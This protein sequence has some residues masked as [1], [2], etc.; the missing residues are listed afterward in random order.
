MPTPHQLGL[1]EHFEQF[2]PNQLE[3][4]AKI[5]NDS[6]FAFLLEAPTGIGKTVIS[7]TAQAL[8]GKQAIHLVS[9]KQLQEQILAD[10][11]D[12]RTLKGRANYPC[13]KFKNRF[14]EV[15][16]DLCTH[17]KQTPCPHLHTCAYT[18]AKRAAL[19][20]ELA[21]LNV[22]YFLSEANFVGAFSGRDFMVADEIDSLENQLMSFV[23]LT[24]FLR[25]IERLGLQPPK[26][27]TKFESW[28]DWG[29]EMEQKIFKQITQLEMNINEWGGMDFKSLKLLKSYQSFHSKLKFFLHEVDKNWVF[30]PGE[31]KWTFKPTWVAKYGNGYLWKHTKK[32]L[33]MSATIL[34]EA[35]ICRNI[36]ITQ[37]H[38]FLSLPSVFPQENRPIYYEPCAD[39]T[40]KNIEFAL[41]RIAKAI[42]KIMNRYPDYHILCHTVS[43]KLRNYLM[44]NL[45]KH[46]L[47]THSIK[48]RTEVLEKFKSSK[49]PLV[50]LSPSMDRGVDLPDDQCR[51]VIIAKVP[52]PDTSDPQ[53][54]RR[55]YASKDGRRWYAHQ[56]VSKLVQASGRGMRSATDWCHTYVLDEQF[57]R[58]IS[59][60]RTMFPQWWI[61]SITRYK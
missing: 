44:D 13:E 11:P 48:D 17:T 30:Y 58:L 31:T 61:K 52:W 43:Y 21:V 27:K 41:P 16:A 8:L 15:N 54:S 20:A 14:P 5:A 32:V 23:E 9:T 24:V 1:P 6:H 51:V 3:T 56:T 60:W 59:D 12:A 2:R 35:Q 19:G 4:A 42:E 22:A 49:N 36:G 34:D 25:Q 39:V 33:G 10:F 57:S 50:L 18:V 7:T 26:Y 55:L 37:D 53:V 38:T 47:I 29:K 46:R 28:V 45:P 40:N